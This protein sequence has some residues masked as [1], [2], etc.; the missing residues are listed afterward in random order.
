M[1]R[2][3]VFRHWTLLSH[4]SNSS[5]RVPKSSLTLN[6]RLGTRSSDGAQGSDHEVLEHD[7][8]VGAVLRRVVA[9]VG[10]LGGLALALERALVA[11]GGGV[12]AGWRRAQGADGRRG[13]G[14]H[15]AASRDGAHKRAGSVCEWRHG[16]LRIQLREEGA[17]GQR[18]T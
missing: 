12:I 5:A 4:I 7:V 15:L 3:I 1:L 16:V 9:E 8:G 17:R 6:R 18:M 10:D 2:V 11:A 13:R 14:R